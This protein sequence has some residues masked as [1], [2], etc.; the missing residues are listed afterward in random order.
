[1]G[2]AIGIDLGT[3]NSVV[4]Y[5]HDGK[6]VVIPDPMGRRLMPSVVSFPEHGPILF[7]HEAAQRLHVDAAR[8]VY[9]VKRLMGQSI[10]EVSGEA[11]L[12]PYGVEAGTG[13]VLKISV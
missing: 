7:G 8:T 11:A 9:S 2:K 6:P 10:E 5:V 3:T 4:A 1:M 13:G 12:L